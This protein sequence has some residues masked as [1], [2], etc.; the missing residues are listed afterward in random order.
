MNFLHERPQNRTNLLYILAGSNKDLLK[1][2][3]L[4]V[5][6]AKE[7]NIIG[8]FKRCGMTK[9]SGLSHLNAV[10][11]AGLVSYSNRYSKGQRAPKLVVTSSGLKALLQQDITIGVKDK[12]PLVLEGSS[13]DSQLCHLPSSDNLHKLP[14]IEEKYKLPENVEHILKRDSIDEDFLQIAL[15]VPVVKG[16]LTLDF[17]DS[18]CV[19][20]VPKDIVLSIYCES[21]DRIKPGWSQVLIPYHKYPRII[22]WREG[23]KWYGI[24]SF[25]GKRDFIG[26]N[27]EFSCANAKDMCQ[28][29][30]KWSS[31]GIVKH[32]KNDHVMFKIN[33]KRE[34]NLKYT[35]NHHIHTYTQIPSSKTVKLGEDCCT[36]DLS[37]LSPESIELVKMKSDI[38]DSFDKSNP[39]RAMMRSNLQSLESDPYAMQLGTSLVSYNK[40]K[41]NQ[42][43][44]RST[45]GH[46]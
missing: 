30:C 16:L 28:A 5:E 46:G 39:I 19:V 15:Q 37:L 24:N 6:A 44:E 20:C 8:L 12:K 29:Q 25:G 23:K 14:F 17:I 21:H 26:I 32:G 13:H 35:R 33:F 2:D 36:I 11:D 9:A 10:I 45:S 42:Q 43:K 4:S 34:D 31:I 27:L 1:V 41:K 3:S 18:N 7:M 40:V 38:S 22:S